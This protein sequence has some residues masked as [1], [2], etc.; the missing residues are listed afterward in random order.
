MSLINDGRF[1][2][3]KIISFDQGEIIFSEGDESRDLFII[4]EGEVG[5]YKKTDKGEIKLAAFKKGDFFGDMALLQGGSRFAGARAQSKTTVLVLQPGGFLLKIRR[6][7]T[8]AF[9]MLQSLSYRIKVSNDRL[10][11]V[12]EK[13]GIQKEMVEEILKTI[14]G[15]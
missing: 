7:P 6:D 12:I 11:G 4:Q 15:N 1:A 14:G 3:E 5:I 8:F 10:L 13:G 2:N 9:E